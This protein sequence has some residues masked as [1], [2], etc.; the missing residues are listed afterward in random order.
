MRSGTSSVGDNSVNR[1]PWVR[2]LGFRW[3]L[4]QEFWQSHRGVAM[5]EFAVVMPVLVLLLLPVVD[6]GMGFYAKT[7]MMT[8]A[9]AGTQW[10]FANSSWNSTSI[11]TA[12]NNATSLSGL[13][14]LSSTSPTTAMTP[15]LQCGCTDG[16]T[17]TLLATDPATPGLCKTSTTTYATCASTQRPG[18]Y[19]TVKVQKNYTPLF[20]YWIFGGTAALTASSTVRIQ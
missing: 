8:A 7:Q 19:V 16:T 5:I 2:R 10:A 13:T 9:E 6:L 4:L 12:V 1:A 3:V 18:A 11:T 14:F 20:G 17:I 15:R